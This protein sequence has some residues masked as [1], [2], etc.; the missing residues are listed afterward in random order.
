M[1]F[2]LLNDSTHAMGQ[3]EGAANSLLPR[4][5]PSRDRVMQPLTVD[6]NNPDRVD[7]TTAHCTIKVAV[8]MVT[9]FGWPAVVP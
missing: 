2:V 1:P 6:R 7:L 5:F 9:G 3:Y 4:V 8:V